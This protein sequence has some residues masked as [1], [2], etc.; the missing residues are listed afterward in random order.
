LL[1]ATA[2]GRVVVAQPGLVRAFDGI[3]PARLGGAPARPA[4]VSWDDVNQTAWLT[5]TGAGGATI[6]ARLGGADGRTDLIALPAALDR[7]AAIAQIRTSGG[8]AIA[9][10][11][12]AAVVRFDLETGATTIV[13]AGLAAYGTPVLVAAPTGGDASWYVALRADRP[14]GST[15][16]TL[17]KVTAG[18]GAAQPID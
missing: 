16:D 1:A 17:V 15:S 6:V 9:G 7:M 18:S 4:S 2:D 3:T 13:T 11:S 10:A 14:G 12:G 8:A 5:G